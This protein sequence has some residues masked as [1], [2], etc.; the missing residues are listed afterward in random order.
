MA[1]VPGEQQRRREYRTEPAV[2]NGSYR[3]AMRLRKAATYRQLY[4]HA[5]TRLGH[6]RL[7]ISF[8]HLTVDSAT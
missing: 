1:G 2:V 4:A 6:E 3:S 8:V 7:E 5:L